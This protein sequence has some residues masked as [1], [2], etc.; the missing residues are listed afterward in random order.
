MVENK[1]CDPTVV[2]NAENDNTNSV[3]ISS[4]TYTQH[5]CLADEAKG[6]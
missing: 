2:V 1:L 4:K 5:C 3:G 6:M